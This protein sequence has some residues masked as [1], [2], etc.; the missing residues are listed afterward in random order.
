MPDRGPLDLSFMGSG[1]A[2]APERCW[3][4]FVLN[5]RHLFDAPPT[6]LYSLKQMRL[7]LAAVRTI[8]ISHFH[9][10]H[11]FGLPFL[12]LEY[13]YLTKRTD[14]LTIVGPPG[15]EERLTA[16]TDLGYPSLLHQSHGYALR[17]VEVN[18]G[19]CGELNDLRYE[20]VEVEHGGGELQCFGFRVSGGG[21]TLAY[22]GDTSYCEQ[23]VRLGKGADV[24]V[25]DCTYASG[26]NKPE[27]MSY[28]EIVELQGRLGGNTQLVLTHL[29]TSIE[30]DGAPRI[31][32]AADQASYSF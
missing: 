11:F 27:H 9:A 14:D 20:A 19:A 17:Y 1:N 2:F 12:L 4:G 32:V 22:T 3:S 10:D 25:S 30:T 23:L 28:E 7:P 18:D 5:Q 16:L 15:I 21:R 31:T 13:A 6:A 8:F 24:L 29:G 26:R